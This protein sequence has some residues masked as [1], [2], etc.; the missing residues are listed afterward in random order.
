M[1]WSL[2]KPQEEAEL[3]ESGVIVPAWFPSELPPAQIRMLLHHT[4]AGS[5]RLTPAERLV[6]VVDGQPRVSAVAHELQ[7]EWEQELGAPF[8]VLDLPENRGKGAA[9]GV[10][11]E[12]LGA[13]AP[14]AYCLTRDAD[15]DH[16][17]SDMPRLAQLAEQVAREQGTDLV[18]II[19]GRQSLHRPMNWLR[20]ELELWVDEVATEGYKL[21]RA[22]EGVALSTQYYAAYG[23]Y[24]DL[25]S[26]CKLYSAAAAR[27]GA[28]ALRAESERY[29]ELDLLRWGCEI[30]PLTEVV[31]AGGIVGEVRRLTYEGQPVSGYQGKESITLYANQLVWLAQRLELTRRQA[32]Q[33]LDNALLRREMWSDVQGREVALGIRSQVL[34]ALS[35]PPAPEQVCAPRFC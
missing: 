7:E 21:V 2:A 26:G 25:E 34:S 4:L 19:G 5:Q 1:D 32:A 16:R 31:L 13:E 30:I 27:L 8:V 28:Q 9:V 10:G 12:Y 11:L 3:P 18:T 17:V 14:G 15:G 22:R 23:G 33:L 20:G 29:P 6:V 35:G 24:A